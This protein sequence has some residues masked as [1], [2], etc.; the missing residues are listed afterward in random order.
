MKTPFEVDD[1]VEISCDFPIKMKGLRGTITKVWPFN[2]RVTNDFYY[3][4]KL[5]KVFKESNGKGNAD[6]VLTTIGRA[7]SELTLIKKANK[8]MKI[9]HNNKDYLL[10][11]ERAIEL[12]VL[13]QERP[14]L[15]VGDVYMG[16]SQSTFIIL[17]EDYGTKGRFILIGSSD[18][19]NRFSGSYDEI[20]FNSSFSD[21]KYLGN[22]NEEFKGLLKDFVNRNKGAS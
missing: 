10:N 15:R 8:T 17:I 7:H 14:K 21:W 6:T 20:S 2:S 1:Y 3:D 11:V 13:K 18:G 19:L 22:I 5:E 9:T 16:Y 4:F 12:G